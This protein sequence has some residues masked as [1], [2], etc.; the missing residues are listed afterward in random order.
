MYEYNNMMDGWNGTYGQG[1]GIMS[2]IFMSVVMALFVISIILLIRYLSRTSRTNATHESAIDVLK[3]RY[4]SGEIDKKQF[5]Q[6]KKDL[7][8][9]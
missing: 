3:R 9:K 5:D 2:L 8:D 6:T 4:A 1:N 7:N